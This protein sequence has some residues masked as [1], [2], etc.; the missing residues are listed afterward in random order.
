MNGVVRVSS[1]WTEDFLPINT[2]TRPGT[3]MQSVEGI[4]WHYTASPG[5]SDENEVTFFKRESLDP[6]SR[7]ASAH[8][9]IDKD[10]AKL[11]IPL[12][13]V[14]YHAG[15]S[16]YNSH[17]IGIEL[18][19]EKDGSF[20][21][22]T[23]ER[24]RNIG[25]AL[26]KQFSINPVTKF[27]RHFDVTGKICPKPWVDHPELFTEFKSQVAAILKGVYKMTPADGTKVIETWL[28]PAY[29]LARSD[30]DRKEIGRLA[31][32]IRKASGLKPQNG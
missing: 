13:E 9:F 4:V 17:Y 2:H 16:F 5:A 20:H 12:G 28:Q 23:L 7:Y 26:A 31:D 22:D 27:I 21:P 3:K 1:L 14:A 24:A 8:F 29:G 11:D 18:C 19:I 6:N 25:A 10:S 15:N 32:E 30:A